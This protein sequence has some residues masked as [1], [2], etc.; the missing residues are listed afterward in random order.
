M[1]RPTSRVGWATSERV[2]R[3]RSRRTFS[4]PEK[5][6][7]DHFG[8]KTVFRAHLGMSQNSVSWISIWKLVTKASK[9]V[10]YFLEPLFS[11]TKAFIQVGANTLFLKMKLLSCHYN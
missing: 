8:A 3:Y 11:V 7:T 5:Q 10:V 6:R 1:G 2:A 9:R 4:H